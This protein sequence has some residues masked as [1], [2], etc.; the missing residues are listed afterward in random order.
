MSPLSFL[1]NAES[2]REPGGDLAK[3]CLDDRASCRIDGCAHLARGSYGFCD[4][5]LVTLK[6]GRG[7]RHVRAFV[8]EARGAACCV[9]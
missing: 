7:F 6:D 1:S 2:M 5:R 8:E 3:L 4:P 9:I